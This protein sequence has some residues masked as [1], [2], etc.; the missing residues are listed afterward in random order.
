MLEGGANLGNM[1]TSCSTG[2]GGGM[3]LPRISGLTR[4]P[5]LSGAAPAP[6]TG[7]AGAAGF[8]FFAAGCRSSAVAGGSRFS[9]R[10][11]G[12]A[13]LW[14]ASGWSQAAAA[15]PASAV[16]DE[17]S[18]MLALVARIAG[19]DEGAAG[20]IAVPFSGPDPSAFGPVGV[21][22]CFLSPRTSS[23]GAAEAPVALV[24][25]VPAMSSSKWPFSFSRSGAGRLPGKTVS[26]N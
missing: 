18:C 4:A 13:A 2:A 16:M 26:P 21:P 22:L 20:L 1:Q 7:L 9:G 19:S 23:V 8:G 17:T 15:S 6:P 10:L 3:A 24:L 11:P 14:L 25:D 12:A 5:R